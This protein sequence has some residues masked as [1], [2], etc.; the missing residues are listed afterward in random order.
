MKSKLTYALFI[1]LFVCGAN[2]LNAHPHAEFHFG[3]GASHSHDMGADE[4]IHEE[5]DHFHFG[6]GL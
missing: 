1:S 4:E 3:P 5:D 6:P 2:F